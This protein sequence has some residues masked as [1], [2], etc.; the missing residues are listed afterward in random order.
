MKLHLNLTPNILVKESNIFSRPSL[1]DNSTLTN[2]HY[3]TDTCLQ[4]AA[5]LPHGC[6][7]FAHGAM[8]LWIIMASGSFEKQDGIFTNLSQLM[9]FIYWGYIFSVKGHC[10]RHRNAEMLAC[11]Y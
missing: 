11:F 5:F 8:Q 9:F 6:R 2:P 10:L 1:Y 7:V 3:K 4:S